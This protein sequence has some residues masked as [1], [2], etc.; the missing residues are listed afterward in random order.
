MHPFYLKFSVVLDKCDVWAPLLIRWPLALHARSSVRV[1]GGMQQHRFASAGSGA[2]GCTFSGTFDGVVR[3]GERFDIS[4]G[5][6]ED[7]GQRLPAL[8]ILHIAV[9]SVQ[10]PIC[11]LEHQGAFEH[12]S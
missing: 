1:V 11:K 5:R 2:V 12:E 8:L 7:T 9:R 4:D 3:D 6:V 10:S